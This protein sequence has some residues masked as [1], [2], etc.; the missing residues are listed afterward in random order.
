MVVQ[1]AFS[2]TAQIGDLKE[3]SL[4]KTCRAGTGVWEGIAGMHDW[5]RP[6]SNN[7][8]FSLSHLVDSH[9]ET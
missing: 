3:S 5:R 2:E 4:T 8:L 1:S 6:E 7:P 9:A